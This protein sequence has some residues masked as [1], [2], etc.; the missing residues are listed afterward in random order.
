MGG[1]CLPAIER[2]AWRAVSGDHCYA[3]PSAGI[4]IIKSAHLLPRRARNDL[5]KRDRKPMTA[6]LARPAQPLPAWVSV[7][8]PYRVQITLDHG[9]NDRRCVPQFP[10]HQA[11]WQDHH[12]S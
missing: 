7:A 8:L 2:L 11:S 6:L 10:F 5:G 12:L 9:T 4:P 1:V 3:L